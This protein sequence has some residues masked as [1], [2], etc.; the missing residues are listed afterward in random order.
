MRMSDE[1]GSTDNVVVNNQLLFWG[2]SSSPDEEASSALLSYGEDAFFAPD[3]VPVIQSECQSHDA[4]D[5]EDAQESMQ[6]RMII[7]PLLVLAM[8]SLWWMGRTMEARLLSST[9]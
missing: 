1:D 8:S 3:P 7:L 9:A 6:Q 2:Q 4:I 5:N